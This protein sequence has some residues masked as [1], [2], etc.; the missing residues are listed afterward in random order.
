[1][2]RYKHPVQ[3]LVLPRWAQTGTEWTLAKWLSDWRRGREPSVAASTA[4][5]HERSIEA[6][7]EALGTIKLVD[8]MPQDIERFYRRV[9]S[10]GRRRQYLVVQHHQVLRAALNHA[11]RAGYL[12]F[13]PIAAVFAPRRPDVEQEIFTR[14]EARIFLKRAEH[15]FLGA[16]FFIAV[17]HGLRLG[18][19]LALH[20]HDIDLDNGLLFVRHTLEEIPGRPKRLTDPKTP[21]SRRVITLSEPV[22]NALTI[23]L[24]DCDPS[25][26][27]A[28]VFHARNG[29]YLW[30]SYFL[31]C[32]FYPLLGFDDRD[33]HTLPW[34]RFHDLRHGIATYLLEDGVDR[35]A[36]ADLLGHASAITTEVIYGH[37]LPARRNEMG[38]LVTEA[39]RRGSTEQPKQVD[40]A[41]SVFKLIKGGLDG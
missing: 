27:A 23:H 8:L 12:I 11:V 7:T 20:W 2:G 40:L 15:S 22:L 3:S 34:I 1:M 28:P 4:R 10:D 6:I 41:R 26:A 17:Y 33:G 5:I 36:V 14:E 19:L 30:R 18:E 9:T 37:V 25:L 21:R 24:I 32:Y 29:A 13:N 16:L 35:N 38:R 39:L 31:R